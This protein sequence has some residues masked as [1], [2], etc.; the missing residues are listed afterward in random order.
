MIVR[1]PRSTLFPYTTLFR[2]RGRRV[3]G[4]RRER[5]QPRAVTT[6]LYEGRRRLPRRQGD[7]RYLRVCPARPGPRSAVRE[8][9]PQQLPERA[10]LLQ[11]GA[12][13]AIAR[14]V[15]LLPQLSGIPGAGAGG[16][17][18][19]PSGVLLGDR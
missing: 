6:I 14:D 7:P 4:K 19:R 1:P 11:P 10:D 12:A 9:R 18:S 15:S 13:A 2:S 16:R 17:G 8:A 3:S 5:R